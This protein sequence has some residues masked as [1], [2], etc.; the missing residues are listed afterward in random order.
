MRTN[1]EVDETTNEVV[2]TEPMDAVSEVTSSEEFLGNEEVDEE[3]VT[4]NDII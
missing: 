4:I 2:G 3:V 1:M